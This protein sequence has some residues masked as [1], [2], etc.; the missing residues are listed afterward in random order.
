VRFC[1]AMLILVSAGCGSDA[2]PPEYGPEDV[3]FESCSEIRCPGASTDHTPTYYGSD[4]WRTCGWDCACAFGV[5]GMT[6]EQVW[7]GSSS[8]ACYVE[9][10]WGAFPPDSERNECS[11]SPSAH[12]ESQLAQFSCNRISCPTADLVRPGSGHSTD[13][14]ADRFECGWHCLNV[15]GREGVSVK[16]QWWRGDG[17][18]WERRPIIMHGPESP[19]NTCEAE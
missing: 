12:E 6:V 10:Y 1:I 2:V 18:C 3:E 17:G 8:G 13:L 14:E 5:C 16:M 4:R 15:L 11:E 19:D 7:E 9:D